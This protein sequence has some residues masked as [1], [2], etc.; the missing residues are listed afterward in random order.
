MGPGGSGWSGSPLPVV[1]DPS[2]LASGRRPLLPLHNATLIHPA[3]VTQAWP[4]ASPSASAGVASERVNRPPVPLS[5]PVPPSQPSLCLE[6]DLALSGARTA[7]S[8]VA[9]ERDLRTLR[10]RAYVAGVTPKG[11]VQKQSHACCGRMCLYGEAHAPTYWGSTSTMC[12]PGAR[13]SELHR[14]AF[15]GGS[16]GF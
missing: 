14:V 7:G 1:Q 13:H 8:L 11:G 12:F 6:L 10:P 2:T 16:R 5:A 3:A 15:G 4:P 9:L